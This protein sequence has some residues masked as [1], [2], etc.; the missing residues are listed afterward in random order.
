MKRRRMKGGGL[1]VLA[2]SALVFIGGSLV[3]F[4]L[5]TSQADAP[6]PV[7]TCETRTVTK[8][9]KLTPN[10]VT[11][12]VF[13][14]SRTAGLANRIS[15]DLQRRG[16]LTGTVANNTTD[17]TTNDVVILTAD[18]T[19]PRVRLA[20]TQ[21]AGKVSYIDAKV[22]G[23]KGVSVLVG[24]NYATRKL[25]GKGEKPSVEVDRTVKTCVPVLPVV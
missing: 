23:A 2:V 12:S 15:I 11:I 6:A 3:G 24:S 13:N 10:L 20:R 14:A 8:G 7:A 4:N 16:F 9:E 21:F 22:P 1:L 19:D 18:K 17:I 5:L 25:S